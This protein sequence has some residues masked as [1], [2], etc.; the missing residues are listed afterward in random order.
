MQNKKQIQKLQIEIQRSIFL[1]EEAKKL[2]ISVLPKMGK[3]DIESVSALFGHADKRQEALF[4]R[5]MGHD[6]TFVPRMK[7][8]IKGEMRNYRAGEE[9]TRRKKEKAEDIL[10]GLE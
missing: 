8:F 3:K 5:M 10:K 2:L 1:K 9:K 4:A 7:F 6:D